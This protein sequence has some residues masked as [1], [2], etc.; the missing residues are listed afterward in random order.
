M[1]KNTRT[2][3]WIINK[4]TFKKKYKENMFCNPPTMVPF[5]VPQ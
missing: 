4:V 2:L 5:N 3:S 1:K